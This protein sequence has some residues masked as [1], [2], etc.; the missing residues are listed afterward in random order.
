MNIVDMIFEF[1]S[2]KSLNNVFLVSYHTLIK[3]IFPVFPRALNFLSDFFV[4]IKMSLF[5]LHH[6]GETFTTV[7]FLPVP[8]QS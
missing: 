6:P 5:Y 8:L 1:N 3:K 7:P 2:T 4:N